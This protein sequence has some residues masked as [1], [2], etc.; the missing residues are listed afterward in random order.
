MRDWLRLVRLPNLATA[1]ADPLAGW[2]VCS[3]VREIGWLPV[4]A[5]C[6]LGAAVCLYAAGMVLNDVE[7]VALDRV[8]RPERPL[9]RGAID[10][11][12]ARRVAHGLFGA[13]ALA[14]CGAAVASRSPWP[15]LVGA[16]LTAAVWLYDTGAR[17]TVAGPAVMGSCRGLSWLLGMT[18]AGGP[19]GLQD[20]AIPVG[21][22][23]YVGGI[24]LFARDEAGRSRGATLAGGLGL[25]LAGL[26][27]AAAAVWWP[28]V[29]GGPLARTGTNWLL[30][31]SLL[32]ASVTV[33]CAVALADPSPRN[34][35]TAVGNAIMSIITL[36]AALVYAAC[37]PAWAVVVLGLLPVFLL[38][39][40]LVPPT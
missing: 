13:G 18:A 14:T 38:G 19:H 29:A 32:A 10:V 12:V 6:G 15:A 25:M 26:V 21:M 23:V 34:V 11:A 4:E 30:L 16:V 9:P 20:W 28:V 24:T 36:D 1:V 8:E 33:R 37:G 5:W 35:R 39:K 17:R 3:Q 27:V 40:R 31:W 7:D 22:A 2:L